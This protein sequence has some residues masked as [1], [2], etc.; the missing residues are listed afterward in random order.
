MP[1]VPVLVHHAVRKLFSKK[2]LVHSLFESVQIRN[3]EKYKTWEKGCS[4]V[5]P[6]VLVAVCKL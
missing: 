3:S 5:S 1:I 4:K 2:K 6:L